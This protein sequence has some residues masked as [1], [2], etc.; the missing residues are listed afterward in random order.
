MDKGEEK[1]IQLN[2][3]NL[4]SCCFDELKQKIYSLSFDD[5]EL[6]WLL[7]SIED[8][9]SQPAENVMCIHER[10]C[11]YIKEVESYK[12]KNNLIK[13]LYKTYDYDLK[14][15]AKR[16]QGI[17]LREDNIE[18]F[19]QEVEE[20]ENFCYD[21]LKSIKELDAEMNSVYEKY[22]KLKEYDETN[23]EIKIVNEFNKEHIVNIDDYGTENFIDWLLRFLN[24]EQLLDLTSAITRRELV[25]TTIN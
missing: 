19:M 9:L 25:I 14:R 4:I 5:F 11:N 13:R 3:T 7:N 24:E 21:I 16:A 2:L 20:Y 17:T 1:I 23:I 18:D 10:I 6:D 8:R 12:E 15:R 22:N